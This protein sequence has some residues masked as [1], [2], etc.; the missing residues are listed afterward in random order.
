LI[1][2]FASPAIR[3]SLARIC[4][5]SSDRIPKFLLPVIL[6][7]LDAGRRVD[8]SAAVVASWARYAE[9]IDERASPI[10]VVDR[11]RERVMAAAERQLRDPLAF[12]R[13]RELFGGL[14][15]RHEFTAPYLRALESF[16]HRGA[17]ATIAALA[18]HGSL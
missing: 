7:N 10:E 6:D 15:E 3:D 1:Q 5:E 11:R 13:D 2:R 17:R 4:A 14:A 9:G 12:V 16:H 8:L 18:S